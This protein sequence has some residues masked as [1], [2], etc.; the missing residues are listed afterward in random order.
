MRVLCEAQPPSRSTN[1][2]TEMVPT[3]QCLDNERREHVGALNKLAEIAPGAPSKEPLRWKSICVIKS[4]R[5]PIKPSSP[6]EH[7]LFQRIACCKF[8]LPLRPF[9][10]AQTLLRHRVSTGRT[11]RRSGRATIPVISRATIRTGSALSQ[12]IHARNC[13]TGLCVRAPHE[14]HVRCSIRIFFL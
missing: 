9:Q 11:A 13:R 10:Y 5:S 1:S 4:T 3:R 8:V 2:G 14:S 7:E 12:T 6:I